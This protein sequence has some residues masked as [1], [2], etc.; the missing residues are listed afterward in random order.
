M[1]YKIKHIAILLMISL[2]FS[3][4]GTSQNK[5]D[6]SAKATHLPS[7]IN[8]YKNDYPD[9][10]FLSNLGVSEYKSMAEKQAYQ[11]IASAF[12][13]HINA[14]DES[15]E[16][17]TETADK[18]NQTYSE[19]FNITT[20]TDQNL[21]NI[22]TSESYFDEKSGKYYVLATLNKSNTSAM[23][24]EERNK[25]LADAE[26]IY[27]KSKNEND[28]LLKVAYISN[29]IAKLEKVKDI[30]SKLRILDNASMEVHKFKKEH[31]LV[32]ERE[33]LLEAA[34]VYIENSD[35]KIFHMLKAD[36]TDLGFKLTDD[37]EQALIVVDFTIKMED[38]GVV[39]QAAKFVMWNLDVNLNHNDK[40]QTFGIYTSKGRS[41]QL[42]ASA[43]RERA[44]Y[45]IDKKISKEFT[46]FLIKRILRVK[47]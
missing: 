24:Q 33:N 13:V 18:F 39:N 23:Y 44:Y 22:K 16:V 45:D 11:G 21:I 5:K 32:I 12:E 37:K 8:N 46:P 14:V 4:C 41:S 17:T 42:S 38:S 34:K 6:K 27:A 30:E 25:L 40:E 15:T 47:E 1:H 29:S 43:A 36:F 19:V 7:W 2:V 35:D 31:E 10:L 3:A 28:V 26:S 9:K 20:S